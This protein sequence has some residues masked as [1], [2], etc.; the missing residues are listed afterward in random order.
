MPSGSG[1]LP[2]LRQTRLRL[3]PGDHL[4]FDAALSQQRRAKFQFAEMMVTTAAA[5]LGLRLLKV[6]PAV[7]SR[8]RL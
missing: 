3:R 4:K 2:Y 5:G 1:P 8:K 7:R 6:F